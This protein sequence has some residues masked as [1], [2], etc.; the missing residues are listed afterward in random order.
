MV[1]C[2]GTTD[3]SA[4]SSPIAASVDLW[5]NAGQVVVNTPAVSNTA[6]S[7]L[8]VTVMGRVMLGSAMMHP[9]TLSGSRA[10]V[11]TVREFGS[12]GP[13]VPVAYSFALQALSNPAAARTGIV[14]HRRG[15]DLGRGQ[16]RLGWQS[17]SGA[18]CGAT[19]VAAAIAIRRTAAAAKTRTAI[20]Q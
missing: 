8:T 6:L 15:T 13:A 11:K 4:R 20:G 16:L 18:Q 2:L 9:E 17:P 19:P 12:T 1:S 7:S 10:S 3:R 14:H 5:R